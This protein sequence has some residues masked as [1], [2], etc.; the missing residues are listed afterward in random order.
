MSNHIR[1]KLLIIGSGPAGYT[2]AVYATRAMLSPI[3]IQGIQPGG[4]LTI[5]TEVE[6]WPGE[7]EIQGPDLM[8]KMENQAK[9]LGCEII[10]DH[11][12]KLNLKDKPFCAE[13]DNGKLYYADAM[14]LATGAQANWLGLQNEEKFK[15][16]GVSACATCDGFFYKDKVV[17]V[18][19]GGNMAVEEALFLTNFASKVLLI[20]RR[21]TLRAEKILQNRLME[22]KKIQ[23]LWNKKVVDIIGEDNPPS[24]TGL[25]LEDTITS[26]VTDIDT[27]GV[28]V[29]IGHSP[30]SELFVDQLDTYDGG[31]IA[32]KP[33]TTE[34]S[35]E[36]VFAAGDL[37][38]NVY[39]QAVTSAATG[40]MAALDAEKFL[41]ESQGA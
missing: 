34:T 6:N 19:G 9:K 3:L 20:H 14:I 7:E 35:I 17:A 13:G 12:K 15:G 11:I 41:S 23:I 21:D 27:S 37:V 10:S 18:V 22:N 24:V 31:Y 25:I 40:C 30:A 32:T 39:R 16:F 8:I 38:D 29:A 2:A 4:Q 33:G 36:G 5:T 28:F 1:S 26:R